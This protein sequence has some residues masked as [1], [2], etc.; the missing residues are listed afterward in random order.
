M[1]KVIYERLKKGEKPEDIKEMFLSSFDKAVNDY[2]A[3][4]A[5]AEFASKRK[6]AMR[7]VAQ[8]VVDFVAVDSPELFAAWDKGNFDSLVDSM[9]DEVDKM[10][11]TPAVKVL[12]TAK[13]KPTKKIGGEMSDDE[14]LKAFLKGIM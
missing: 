13:V 9:L 8:A 4:T 5:A 7:N 1:Y 11:A 2:K 10:F 3:E 6:D 12:S 14:I